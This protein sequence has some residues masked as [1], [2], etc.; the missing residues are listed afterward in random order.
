M[1][2]K[3]ICMHIYVYLHIHIT[4]TDILSCLTEV[5]L[6]PQHLKRAFVLRTRQYFSLL[7]NVTVE[8]KIVCVYGVELQ[9]NGC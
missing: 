1:I 3:Y 2:L 7:P 5:I 8:E 6:T 4:V 9:K